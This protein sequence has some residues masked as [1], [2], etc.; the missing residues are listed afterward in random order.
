M[1]KCKRCEQEV[2]KRFQFKT[3]EGDSL[4][5]YRCPECGRIWE[6]NKDTNLVSS[7]FEVKWEENK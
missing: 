1:F 5:L 3:E 2:E 7:V 4:Q 6:H